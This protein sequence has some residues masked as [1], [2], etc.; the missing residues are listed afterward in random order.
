MG[1]VD[2]SINTTHLDHYSETT[3]VGQLELIFDTI[4]NDVK[5]DHIIC[6]DFNSLNFSD[7]SSEKLAEIEEVRHSNSWPSI[8]SSVTD[9]IHSHLFVLSIILIIILNV[10]LIIIFKIR[11]II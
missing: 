5:D 6:G 8:S 2:L 4:N 7:Y 11:N 10:V 3:R 1:S 9:L